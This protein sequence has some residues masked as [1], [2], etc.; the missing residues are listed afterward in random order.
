MEP[1]KRVEYN[2]LKKKKKQTF[3]DVT[4]VFFFPQTVFLVHNL[5]NVEPIGQVNV[6]Q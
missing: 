1:P 5:W 4:K 6:A 2:N 3:S